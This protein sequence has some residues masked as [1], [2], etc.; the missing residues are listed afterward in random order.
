MKVQLLT[1]LLQ[2]SAW[3]DDINT[4][5]PPLGLL[6]IAS[7]LEAQGHQCNLIERRRIIHDRPRTEENLA[8]VDEVMMK[9]ILAFRPDV[10]AV[11]SMTFHIMD[12]YRACERIKRDLPDCEIIIGGS[13][14]T[15][16][17]ERT[18]DECPAI[19]VVAKGEGEELMLQ[20]CDGETPREE[21]QG[22]YLRNG[23]PGG[24]T[25][26]GIR[27][28]VDDVTAVPWPALHLV[29]RDFY[30]ERSSQL[31]RGFYLRGTTMFTSRGCPFRCAFCQA[32]QIADSN[33]GKFVRSRDAAD[34]VAEVNHLIDEYQVEGIYF[35][36]DVFTV[37]RSRVEEVCNAFIESGISEKIVWCCNVRVDLVDQDL[38][39]LMKRAGCVKMLFGIESGSDISLRRLNKGGQASAAKNVETIKKCE[40]AGIGCETGI[41]LGLPDDTEEDILATMAMLKECRPSRINRGKLYPIPGTQFY[42]ELFAEGRIDPD[43]PWDRIQDAYTRADFTFAAMTP[44]DFRKL[45]A[46]F[47]REL[48]LP[49]NYMFMV[50][51]NWRH[52]PTV[53]IRQ[54][55]LMV[56]HCTTLRLPLSFQDW[57]RRFLERFRVKSRFVFE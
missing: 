25:F 54:F 34:V 33:E 26:T 40:A 38:L 53:A 30:F 8:E 3:E 52:H 18:L 11:T 44:R 1:P 56:G 9:E 47:D 45:E 12:A 13:H 32:P 48:T 2:K 37:H 16:M 36:D 7:S 28:T 15:A 50:R 27:P 20:F 39:D 22:L 57:T 43:I 17:P 6:Y 4:K 51:S 5:W 21:I 31:F 14:P 41:I 55:L 19:D 46:K 24:V 23:G 49:T 42:T 29:D 10:I 35:S